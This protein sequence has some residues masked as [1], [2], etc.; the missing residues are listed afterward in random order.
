MTTLTQKQWDDFKKA[1]PNDTKIQKVTFEEL[2]KNTEGGKVDWKNPTVAQKRPVELQETLG[3]SDCE[4]N[5]GFVVFD[6]VCLAVGGAGLRAGAG[7]GTAEAVAKAAKPVLSKI[8]G[9][10]AKMAAKGA[11]KTDIAWGVFTILKTIWSGGCLG[12]VVAAFVDSLTWYYML[13][14]AATALATIVAAL[15]TDGAAFVA[16]VVVELATA[17]FLVA[18]SVNAVTA[19]GWA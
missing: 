6:V 8:E 15:A 2:L 19:C 16:E 10:I 5:I 14:Y 3:L 11:S 18:D 9:T 12:A 1:F 17:G 13:L 7:R 4:V